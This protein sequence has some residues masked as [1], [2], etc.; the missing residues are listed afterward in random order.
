M[1]QQNTAILVFARRSRR[2]A[3]A[4]GIPGGDRLFDRLTAE[5]LQ[6]VR[7]SG[8]PWFHIGEGEQLGAC[9]GDRLTHAMDCCFERGFENLIVIGNDSPG[10]T[11]RLLRNAAALL[12]QE[13]AVL[14]PS[15]DG[16]VYLIAVRRHTFVKS[17]FRD[18]PWKED[19]LFGHL[20]EGIRTCNG[21][22]PFLLECLSDL[23]SLG[24][25]RNWLHHAPMAR[26]RILRLIRGLVTGG[27]IPSVLSLL[28]LGDTYTRI[29]YNKGSPVFI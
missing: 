27:A 8:L 13:P 28:P 1:S 19:T 26:G 4:K 17:L 2:D 15:A 3:R 29:H 21:K 10:L 12:E 5:T 7:R 24:D 20:S 14:G 6:K 23:D 25:L 18:L 22:N 9:F 16:G 11:V